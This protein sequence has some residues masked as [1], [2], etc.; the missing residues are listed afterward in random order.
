MSTYP[1]FRAQGAFLGLAIGDAYGRPLKYESGLKVRNKPVS[2][3]GNI[4][5]GT[6]ETYMAFIFN[7]NKAISNQKYS[8]T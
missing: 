8:P 7:P 6:D 4:F 2:L 3:D 5:K 1:L